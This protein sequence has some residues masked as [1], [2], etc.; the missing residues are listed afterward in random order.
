[1]KFFKEKL[2]IKLFL[3]S[4]IPIILFVLVSV[5]YIVPS[6]E[7]DIYEAREEQTRELGEVGL[8]IVEHYYEKEQEGEM[9]GVEAKT[10]AI[11]ALRNARFGEDN[12]DYFWI[13]D[14]DHEMILHPYTPELEGGCVE[15][16]QD[17][18]GVYLFQEAVNI[19]QSEGEG[20]LEYQWQYYDEEDRIE[21]KISY[22]IG[23]EEWDWVIGTGIYVE[24]IQP[25][26]Q[27][28]ILTLSGFIGGAVVISVLITWVL[29]NSVI[30]KP[31][32]NIVAVAKEYGNGNLQQEVDVTSKD[33]LGQLA[34]AFNNMGENIKSLIQGVKENAE[35]VASS[36]EEL[37]S[38]TEENK[39]AADE[40]SKAVE[41][42]A[43]GASS[44]AEKTE[45]TFNSTEEFGKMID[46]DQEYVKK[47]DETI[48]EVTS[49]KEGGLEVVENLTQKTEENNK[50]AE[51]IYD[52]I[53]ETKD[54]ADNIGEATNTIKD[55]AEQTNL[56]ALNAS[57][58]A[59]RAG[60][61]GAGFDVVANEIRKLAENANENSDKISNIVQELNEKSTKAVTTMEEVQGIVGEQN[62]GVEDTRSKFNE[63]SESIQKVKEVAESLNQTGQQMQDKKQ[64]IVNNLQDLSS[65]AQENSSSTEEISSSVEEQTASMDEIAK[66]S[67]Q[68]ANLAEKMQEEISKFNY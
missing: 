50:A 59:A 37:S 1:M 22:V 53:K 35:Q 12:Q 3:L 29:S 20:H 27:S 61:A 26:V 46:N 2:S 18:E 10:A 32:K 8:S 52:V 45:Q 28:R 44:Q 25:L 42:I 55:I 43:E 4:L 40:V 65:I 24:D 68:L 34:T 41:E 47:L 21:P 6:T 23:F 60:E 17:P 57:I 63:I 51:S 67:E 11:E 48:E 16:H 5:F 9:T 54:S 14:Y 58:E 56:L 64:E 49:L 7:N 36:S 33:E 66:A 39:N 30:I 38:N 19:A 13:N 31:L 62:Q 15:D